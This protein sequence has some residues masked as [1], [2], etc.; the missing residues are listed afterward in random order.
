MK[1]SIRKWPPH[2]GQVN[3]SA[4]YTFRIGRAQVCLEKRRKSSSWTASGQE[5]AGDWSA[6][7]FCRGRCPR[8]LLLYLSSYR[9][10]RQ[11]AQVIYTRLSAKEMPCDGPWSENNVQK[12]KDWMETGMEP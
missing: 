12:F 11:F 2:L 4:R 8:A 7:G 10:V 1:L 9:D 6:A 5:G 3:G